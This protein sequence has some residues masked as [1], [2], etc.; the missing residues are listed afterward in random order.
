MDSLSYRKRA[1]FFS[2]TVLVLL[3]G[4]Y[5]RVAGFGTRPFWSDEAWVA[6]A[7]RTRT[8]AQVLRQSAVPV[9]PLF[10]VAV[11]A[12]GS[13]TSR[14]E[15][16]LRLV[17]LICGLAILPTAWLA[18][19]LLRLPRSIILVAMALLASSTMLVVW[20]RELKQYAVE[21]FLSIFL[22]FLVFRLRRARVGAT[23]WLLAAGISVLCAVGPWLGYGFVFGAATLGGALVLL[24]PICG[25]RRA[26]IAMGIVALAILGISILVVLRF[27]ASAQ[28]SDPGLVAFTKNWYIRPLDVNSWMRAGA[29][30]CFTSSAFLIPQYL[31][32]LSDAP[33]VTIVLV[34]A[35]IWVVAAIGLAKWVRESRAE[36][37]L[38]VLGPWLLLLAAAL[39]GKYPFC[40][41]RM[42]VMWAAPLMI[43]MGAG[44][45][46]LGR[47]ISV[48]VFGRGGAGIILAVVLSLLPVAHLCVRQR[49]HSVCVHH[50]FPDLLNRLRQQR[51]AGE[52]VMVTL[53]A[54][55]AVLY[56]TA[57][58]SIP[59]KAMP[60]TAGTCLIPGYPYRELIEEKVRSAG[61]RLWILTTTCRDTTDSELRRVLADHKYEVSLVGEDVHLSRWGQALL[62]RAD[63]QE[64]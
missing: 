6:D 53:T 45:V 22:A 12:I 51:R 58:E 31:G 18:L 49:Q 36:M 59:I 64:E 39:A 11:K 5:G 42:M 56:Y 8:Y 50:D 57:G 47:A 46:H 40:S 7:V 9:P 33:L 20:S 63:K 61:D 10:G 55:P 17:P 41:T 35:M 19:R 24:R 30:F 44:L 37:C 54:A 38:Y 60:S 25:S 28:G 21:A 16:G 15:V 43:A 26:S 34:T 1:A 2:C 48:L 14:P 13:L 27:V 62:L 52:P 23:W 32:A 4:V 3:A 29:C